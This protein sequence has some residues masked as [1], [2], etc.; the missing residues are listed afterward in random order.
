MA[1]AILATMFFSDGLIE[2][3]L[4]AK[5]LE[6]SIKLPLKWV[7]VSGNASDISIGSDGSIFALDE[8]G[9]VWLRQMDK[10]AANLDERND[11][12][13]R[14]ASLSDWTHLPGKFARIA[15]AHKHLAWAI[16]TSGV[17]NVWNG[18]LWRSMNKQFPIE[19]IDVGIG[20]SG[21]AYAITSNGTLVKLDQGRGLIAIPAPPNMSN[22]LI[23]IDV[24]DQERP[25]VVAN[26]G[27]VYLLDQSSWQKQSGISARNLSVSSHK[28]GGAWF[29]EQNGQVAHISPDGKNQQHLAVRANIIAS[30]PNGKPWIVTTDGAIYANEPNVMP[31][32]QQDSTIKKQVFTQL[33]NWQRTNGNAKQLAI[34]A[35]GAVLALGQNGEIWY[36]KGNNIWGVLPGALEYVTI[37]TAGV[38]WG[39]DVQGKIVRYQGSYWEELPGKARLI[40]AG[41]DGSI[42]IVSQ[43]NQLMKWNVRDN[44]WIP[45]A[46]SLTPTVKRLAISADGKPW[47]LENDGTVQRYDEKTWKTLPKIAARDLDIGPEGTAFVVDDQKKLWRFDANVKH[48]EELNGESTHVA[49]GP[50][51]TPWVT[52][53][54][55]EI[56]A[57]SF[58]DELPESKVNTVSAAMANAEKFNQDQTAPSSSGEP[59]SGGGK[60]ALGSNPNEG[61][62]FQKLVGTPR[63]LAI[64]AEGSVF[65]INFDGSILRWNNGRNTFLGFPGQFNHIAVSPKGHPWGVTVKGEVFRHD[66]IEW[67]MVNNITAS[68]IA[69]GYNGTVMVIGPLNI[70]YKYNEGVQRFDPLSGPTEEDPLPMG[71]RIAVDPLGEPWVILADGYVARCKKQLCSRI[72]MQARDISIGPEGSVFIIDKNNSLRRWNERSQTFDRL[73]TIADPLKRVTV[74]PRG[75]PWII[76]AKSETWSSAF[77]PRDESQDI[78]VSLTS[79]DN[80]PIFSFSTRLAFE[81]VPTPYP[82]GTGY[83]IAAGPSG[84]VMAL[85]Q[86]PTLAFKYLTYD[87]NR[88]QFL[89]TNIPAPPGGSPLG[90]ATGLA[91]GPKDELWTWRR[92][93]DATGSPPPLADNGHVWLRNNNNWREVIGIDSLNAVT[94]T[95]VVRDIDISIA[96]D[97]SITAL[98]PDSVAAAP[99]DSK[100]YRYVPAFNKFILNANQFS[101]NEDAMTIDATGAL[102]LINNVGV[103]YQFVN[104]SF[105][106]RPLPGNLTAC[107]AGVGGPPHKGCIAAGVNGSV[108]VIGADPSPPNLGNKLYRWNA[109]N[110]QWDKVVTSPAFGSILGIAVASDG[111]PWIITDLPSGTI[112]IYKAK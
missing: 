87:D 16:E 12:A 106:K 73:E 74:G 100:L 17:L 49:V 108:Y 41:P 23:L 2:K 110:T 1:F 82:S 103:P 55:G 102:W 104:N 92:V 89:D 68:D 63:E 19:A 94:A 53:E 70:L 21:E 22:N 38:A 79:S 39:L 29:V 111:R 14:S 13:R 4:S 33:I 86:N 43:D 47:I 62:D 91:I 8:V 44:T 101:G 28:I 64:G 65:G 10:M 72:E 66:G 26:D 11:I 76:N 20:A 32:K 3:N 27:G 90:I 71:S 35:K 83:A 52:R 18:T 88:R 24:D 96:S 81:K 5:E 58:F 34:S 51:G 80:E 46:L 31:N 112:N 6:S 99:V 60:F 85:V 30:A 78:S 67:R 40:K 9:N 69:I 77:F 61:L 57:A 54:N 95:S 107:P 50:S 7:S 36:W 48:W 56:L 84:K 25:W 37:D 98:S 42:W 75:K 45:S 109:T 15:V 105:I 97:G 59:A 93:Q